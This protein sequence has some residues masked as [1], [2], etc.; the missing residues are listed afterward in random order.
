MPAADYNAP[1][2]PT[3]CG[4]NGTPGTDC[5]LWP[6]LVNYQRTDSYKVWD[7]V[8]KLCQTPL[9][10][11]KWV[12]KYGQYASLPYLMFTYS[13]YTNSAGWVNKILQFKNIPQYTTLTETGYSVK[14]WETVESFPEC[15]ADGDQT[16]VTTVKVKSADSLRKF[17]V[18]DMVTI[19]ATDYDSNNPQD[20]EYDYTVEWDTVKAMASGF[21]WSLNHEGTDGHQD[22]SAEWNTKLT[23][24]QWDNSHTADS[25]CTL[26]LRAKI[27]AIN[28]VDMTITFNIPVTVADGDRILRDYHLIASCERFETGAALEPTDYFESF[29]QYFG[30]T[31][32]FTQEELNKCYATPNWPHDYVNAK[33]EALYKS[34]FLDVG[35]A[36]WKG[37]NVK[38]IAGVQEA[39]TMG[40]LPAIYREAANGKN[41]VH[42]LRKKTSDI[43]KVRALLDIFEQAQQCIIEGIDQTLV[44]AGNNK[45]WTALTKLN[46]AWQS[47]AACMPIC[48]EQNEVSFKVKNINTVYGRVEFYTDFFLQYYYPNKSFAVVMPK[49]LTSMWMPEYERLSVSN[50]SSIMFDNVVPGF[51]V[52]DLNILNVGKLGCPTTIQISTRFALIHAGM[53][54]GCWRI[55]EGLY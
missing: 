36:F 21:Q 54:S 11:W 43:A 49:G 35:N 30:W 29:Y 41:I 19:Y 10:T 38:E 25:C 48:D 18:N 5:P 4:S 47:Y 31:L 28:I 15:F 27:L 55:I 26:E 13:D 1:G 50:G 42:D 53:R 12:C 24:Q 34:L 8:N 6:S 3:G 46:P 33:F 52:E 37:L 20:S 40:I 45:F 2:C 32:T 16:N 51:K 17:F 22:E 9:L 7:L 23:A 44:V 14:W 39:Q